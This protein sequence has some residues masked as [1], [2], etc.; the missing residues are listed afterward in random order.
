MSFPRVVVG[1][2]LR[3]VSRQGGDPRTLRAARPSGMTER[4]TCKV[5][6]TASGFT[7]I[8]LLVVVLIIG[9]LAAVALPQYNI[10]VKKSRLMKYIQV[11]Y[12][13][14][15]AQEVYY[16]ENGT[17]ANS[18]NELDVDYS[19]MC[20]SIS[21]GSAAACNDGFFIENS[22][23]IEGGP[24]ELILVVLCPGYNTSYGEC[25]SHREVEVQIYYDQSS[26]P[27]SVTC[28]PKDSA[29]CR[30]LQNL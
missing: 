30:S 12:G 25:S 2:F 16:M 21:N 13:I 14:K 10:A 7:L 8:E 26:H 29:L 24:K 19:G 20:T 6:N 22:R 4:G 15:R 11:A 17:Y 28:K 3:F 9:I 5:T 23:N 18:F 27:G 1:N